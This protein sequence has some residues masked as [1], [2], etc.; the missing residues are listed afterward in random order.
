MSVRRLVD[1]VKKRSFVS[2]WPRTSVRYGVKKMKKQGHSALLVMREGKI[3]GIVSTNDIT[4]RLVLRGKSSGSTP[5]KDIM[6]SPVH[7]LEVDPHT[8]LEE[9]LARMIYYRVRHL[10]LI[11]EGKVVGLITPLLVAKYRFDEQIGIARAV[12]AVMDNRT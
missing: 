1:E 6:T 12:D 3:L 9:C 5:V 7:Q 4:F 11:E 8:S 2:V 10:P